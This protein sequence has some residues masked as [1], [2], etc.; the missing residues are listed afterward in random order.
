MAHYV[1]PQN[2]TEIVWLPPLKGSDAPST[3][4]KLPSTLVVP[5]TGSVT[6]PLVP[7]GVSTVRLNASA[8]DVHRTPYHPNGV[9]KPPSAD[10]NPDKWGATDQVL[11]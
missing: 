3:C 9:S 10:G 1:E 6:M 7:V 4:T 8:V 11:P 5:L 2:C